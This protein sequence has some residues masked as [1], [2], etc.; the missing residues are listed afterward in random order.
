[1]YGFW[2]NKRIVLYDTLLSKEMNDE[3]K[4]IL[5]QEEAAKGKENGTKES[6]EEKEEEGKNGSDEKKEEKRLGM[7]DDEVVAVLGHELGHW[8]L[9]HT[10]K[11]LIIAEVRCSHRPQR[12]QHSYR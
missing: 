12:E 2:K 8:K 3:L 10:L 1:M 5:E 9:S 7:N 4:K 11:N 6:S